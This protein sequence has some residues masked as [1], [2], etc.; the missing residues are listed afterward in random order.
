VP[1][2][3]GGKGGERGHRRAHEARLRIR[4]RRR[5]RATCAIDRAALQCALERL[6]RRVIADDVRSFDALARGQPDR[7]PD[8][9]DAE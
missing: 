3:L 4:E 8:Q 9:P 6:R 1:E 5:H 7:A 2:R